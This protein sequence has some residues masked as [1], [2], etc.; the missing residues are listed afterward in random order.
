MGG[1]AMPKELKQKKDVNALL[2]VLKK[3][4]I[5]SPDDKSHF[6]AARL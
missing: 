4:D 3:M 1:L 6:R 2:T 5:R